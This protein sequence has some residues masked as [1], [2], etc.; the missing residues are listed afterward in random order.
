MDGILESSTISAISAT[1]YIRVTSIWSLFYLLNSRM[2]RLNTYTHSALSKY[3]GSAEWGR[4]S[5][6]GISG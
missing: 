5:K 6:D 2:G 4:A 1:S 3:Y